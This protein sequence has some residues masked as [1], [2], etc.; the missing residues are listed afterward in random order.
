M[1][2]RHTLQATAAAFAL[3]V[4]M[5]NAQAADMRVGIQ[6]VPPDE[7]FLARDWAAAYDLDLD[8]T[9]FSSGGD[10]LQAFVAGRIHTSNGGSARLVTIAAQQ[11]ERF[12]IIA[13]QQYGGER[14]GVLVHE[15]STAT[16]IEDLKGKTIGG[17]TGSGTFNTFRVF[18]HNQGLS[19]TDFEI[20]NMRVEDLRAAVQQGIIDAAVAWE[21]HVSIAET[22]GGT[23]RLVSMDGVNDSPNF[24]LV[25][26]N[27]A[28]N[29]PDV[30]TRFVAA[31][32]DVAELIKNDPATAGEIAAEQISSRGVSVD[33]AALELSF[34]RIAVDREVTDALIEELIPIAESMYQAGRIN[35]IPDFGAVVNRTFYEEALKIA[36]KN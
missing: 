33:P 1:K 35:H 19:E 14:Y 24:I 10:M 23:R 18:L 34:T 16:S 22:I 17:V 5:I 11:P 13:T 31:L 6:S 27:F 21:P 29:N 3:A 7:V 12:Y 30:V 2:F 4:G 36:G 32:I 25:D 15:D 28:D 20:V 8:I 9:Q 26:R